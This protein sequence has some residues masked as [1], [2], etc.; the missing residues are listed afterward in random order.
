MKQPAGKKCVRC[1]IFALCVFGFLMMTATAQNPDKKSEEKVSVEEAKVKFLN[2]PVKV[3]GAKTGFETK[4]VRDAPY[5]A[6]V[7]TESIQ[8][9]TDGN[10]IKNKNTSLVYRDREGRTRRE[11]EIQTKDKKIVKQIFISDPA[12][13]INYT[14]DE[15]TKKA[16]RIKVNL[17]DLDLSKKKPEKSANPDNNAKAT[18]P[19]AD[20]PQKNKSAGLFEKPSG[21]DASVIESLGRKLIEGLECVGKRTTL[22]I[23]AGAIGNTLPMKIVSDEWFSP[24][25]QVLVLTVHQDPRRGETTYRLINI[26]RSEPDKSLFEVPAGYTVID[27]SEIRK[28]TL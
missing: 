15:N 3:I 4:V 26:K 25:L 23:P 5:S 13:G 11:T 22:T 1:V 2:E 14:L 19:Q 6:A 18:K 12:N 16:F 21:K 24:E 27:N 28:K 10:S 17:Q 8:T 20:S 9:F 7:E